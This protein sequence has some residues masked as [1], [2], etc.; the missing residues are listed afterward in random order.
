M[1]DVNALTYLNLQDAVL[2]RRF[3]AS[4]QRSN[5]KRCLAVAY[6]DVWSAEDWTFKR[7]SRSSFA[8]PGTGT[9]TKPQ[10]PADFGHAIALFDDQGHEI[11]PASEDSLERFYSASALT[12]RP[13]VFTVVNR[14]IILS[15]DPGTVTYQLSYQR[16][17]SSRTAA[18][19]VQAGMMNVDGDYPLWDD[20]HGVLIPRAQAI[21]YLELWD[22]SFADVQ[23]EYER[24]LARMK[25]DYAQ[26]R[27]LRQWARQAWY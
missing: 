9:G 23:A 19:A 10:M 4:T 18:L 7:V 11:E 14:Q 6:Q 20:H 15:S 21:L 1:P 5:A 24:Q 13:D 17:L 27:P 16:R 22:P 25:D 2:G 12:G 3:P 8:I 26:E